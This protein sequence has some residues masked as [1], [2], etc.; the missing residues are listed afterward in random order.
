MVYAPI[1]AA[2]MTLTDHIKKVVPTIVN[3]ES[4]LGDHHL[5]EIMSKR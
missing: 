2:S 5:K 3:E 4:I 1:Y